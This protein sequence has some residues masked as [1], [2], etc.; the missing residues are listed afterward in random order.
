MER[1]R[2]QEDLQKS[3]EQYRALYDQTPLI[4]F[5]VDPQ[6]MIVSVNHYGA[7]ILGYDV[8]ELMGQSVSSV[9]HPSDRSIFLSSIEKCLRESTKNI[10]P[11]LRK[12]KKDGT[13]LWVRETIQAIG[14]PLGPKMVLLSCEDIT[15]K[16]RTEE[17]LVVSEQQL[18]HT[19]KMEAIGTLAGGIAHD[20]N[21]ILGAILGYSELAMA[22]VAQ[23]QRLRSYLQEVQAA[24]QRARD[25]VKQIL[26]FSR[27]SEQER[28]AVNLQL[29]IR[30]VLRMIRASFP[31]SI[32]ILISMGP[33]PAV[34][35]ADASQM[36][37]I[38][39]NLCANAEYAMRDHGGVLEISLQH[40]EV[41]RDM[42]DRM[43]KLKAGPYV[44]LTIRDTGK[45]MSPET[46]ERIFEPFFTTKQAGEGTGLG[47]AVVHGIVHN[48]GGRIT[49]SSMPEVGT[50]FTV[51]FP[52]LDVVVPLKPEEVMDWP[53]GSGK[54]LFVDDEEM[55]TRWGTQLLSHL[56]YSVVSTV[57][58]YEALEWFR[59]TPRDFDVVVTDQTMP[60]MSGDT[61]AR[62]LLDIRQDIPIL[63]CTGFS[64]TMSAEKAKALGIKAFL[65]KPVNGKSLAFALREILA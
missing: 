41:P 61:L 49:V 13:T 12:I 27:R 50:T 57:N 58:P 5:T 14:Q 10:V 42:G 22:Q 52:R 43:V 63:L 17:A 20:F 65:M 34:I 6:G 19:Q 51:L 35:Y 23:D 48:H 56:G 7:R 32:E 21:N 26:A 18:R 46:V 15:E 8:Q 3:R 25:L 24:G 60:T 28:E 53:T 36:Q 16:K 55:L 40:K 62:A 29:V 59:E 30:D 39:M 38:V 31:A 45:G 44:E 1:K 64:Y 2:V 33:D 9:I 37:Q 54:I 11:E 47:L 4:Y